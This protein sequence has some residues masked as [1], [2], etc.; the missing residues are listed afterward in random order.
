MHIRPADFDR[1]AEALSATRARLR[2]RAALRT[3]LQA[4][5]LLGG[6]ALVC[7]A[8]AAAVDAG[9]LVRG[10]TW[11]LLTLGGAAVAFRSL[12]QPWRRTAN[13]ADVAAHLERGLPDLRDG[14]ISTVQFAREWGEADAQSPELVAGLAAVVTDRLDHADLPALTPILPSRRPLAFAGGVLGVWVLLGLLGPAWFNKGLGVLLPARTSDGSRLVG[15]LV[16]DLEIVLTYPAYMKRGERT[17]PNST[18]ELE[19]PAGT[20]ITLRATTLAPARSLALRFDS[21][22]AS[23][24]GKTPEADTIPLTLS[25]ARDGL[26]RFTVTRGGAWRFVVVSDDGETQAE[27]LSR[28]L[29]LEADNPPTVN[30]KL[31]AGD[32]EITDL[33]AIPVEFEASD[34]FGLSKASILLTLAADDEHPERI[35]QPGIQGKRLQGA[36][37]IDLKRIQASSG[38]KIGVSVEVYDNRDGGTPETGPQRTVSAVRWLTIHSPEKA[39]QAQMEKLNE[40]VEQLVG[41]L[42]DRLEMDFHAAATTTV[43][44]RVNAYLTASEAAVKTLDEIVKALKDDRLSPKEVNLALAGRLGELERAVTAER[45]AYTRESAGL[46]QGLEPSLRGLSRANETSIEKVEAT[47]VLIEAMIARLSLEELMALT[48]ELKTSATRLK[49]LLQEYK[50]QPSD[51]LKQRI[52]RDIQRLKTRIQEIRERIA[53]LRQKLP[54]EFLNMEGL[55]DNKAEEGLEK[56]SNQ[57]DDLEKMLNEDRIDDALKAIEAMEKSLDETSGQ[58]DKDMSDLNDSTNPEMQKAI[59]ELMDQTKDLMKQQEALNQQTA[60]ALKE[61]EECLKKLVED[62]FKGQFDALRE[63]GQKLRGLIEQ[64]DPR[65]LPPYMADDVDT[66]RQNVDGFLA[67]LDRP[68]L[69]DA[70]EMGQ[71]AYDGFE[72]LERAL[73]YNDT[74]ASPGTRDALNGG[75]SLGRELLRDTGALQRQFDAAVKKDCEKLQKP[76]PQPMAGGQPPDDPNQAQPQPGQEGQ[77]M[78]QPGAS[79]QAGGERQRQVAQGARRLQQRIGEKSQQIPGLPPEMGQKAGN[80]AQSM[81]QAAGSLDG[82]RPAEA[83]PG[84][85]QAMNELN[86]LMEGLKKA[87]QPQRAD[88]GDGDKEG[89]QGRS[90]N[91]KVEIP[92]AYEA[93]AE[94]RKDLLDA[95]KDKAPEEFQEQVKRYYESLVQ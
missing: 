60:D 84:Q 5:A 36:D 9:R 76:I 38:D 56:T 91:K 17:I 74:P 13:D 86:G 88:R 82:Q 6:L 42:A 67:A 28:H 55:K 37:E 79:G 73:R 81:D 93:P 40:L 25:D 20:Q 2:G 35:E 48:D 50:N 49:G 43:P 14:L 22:G 65:D 39:H 12:F 64:V 34:D 3:T 21:P 18:G 77:P 47:I 46:A 23:A 54:E 19:A 1:I 62:V 66:V 95:M 11:T 78:P 70:L 10:L 33:H 29:R 68:S 16:G 69:N 59:S 57:L 61:Y 27:A 52:R 7:V 89:S 30:L 26:G 80:A 72:S 85:Q 75:R 51:A 87:A 8:L 41:I 83:Q 15:P 53:K 58:L 71:R 92:E 63:R 32:E 94:F 45:A 31:P 90:S 24:G 4:V 44:E